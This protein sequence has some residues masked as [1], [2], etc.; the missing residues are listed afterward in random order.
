[1]SHIRRKRIPA[2][3]QSRISVRLA[4][5]ADPGHARAIAS[6]WRS[7]PDRDHPLR[8]APFAAGRL[9]QHIHN[10]QFRNAAG[11]ARPGLS[12]SR[13]DYAYPVMTDTHYIWSGRGATRHR[14]IGHT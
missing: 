2:N 5:D 4:H 9:R 11:S 8:E 10:Q 12:H 13:L 7:P 14:P 3:S 6:D 1:M